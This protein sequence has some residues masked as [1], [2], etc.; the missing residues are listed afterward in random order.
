M[1]MQDQ[2]TTIREM[3]FKRSMEYCRIIIYMKRI[4]GLS[5]SVERRILKR[6]HGE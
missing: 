2:A 3:V 5:D 4:C 1:E 6:H